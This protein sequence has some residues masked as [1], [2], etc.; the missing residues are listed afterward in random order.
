LP[1]VIFLIFG[2]LCSGNKERSDGEGF[3]AI[4]LAIAAGAMSAIRD[5]MRAEMDAAGVP[6]RLDTHIVGNHVAEL[7]DLGYAAEM[8][9]ETGCSTK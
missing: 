7:N 1:N 6:Q 4:D 9:H 5:R 2:L 8:F 3:L